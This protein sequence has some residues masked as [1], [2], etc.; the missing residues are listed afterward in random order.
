[1]KIAIIDYGAGNIQS[2]QFGLERLG[3]RAVLTHDEKKLKSA[4]RVIFPGVGHAAFAYQQLKKRDLLHVITQLH[5]PVLGICLGM[6]L[7]CISTEEDNTP[8]LGIFKTKVRKFDNAPKSP[9]MGWNEIYGL[10]S[11]L[12]REIPENSY[13]Y[14]VHSYRADVCNEQIATCTYG[15]TFAAALAKDNFFGV[16]F[17]PE[18]S[19]NIGLQI[20]KNFIENASKINNETDSRN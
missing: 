6:Q 14:M 18:K 19:G 2:V 7:L 13:Q 9:H 3:Y 8:G 1:M 20:L 16:Q 4:D 10:K 15:D 17:H 12:F 11:Q 5:M